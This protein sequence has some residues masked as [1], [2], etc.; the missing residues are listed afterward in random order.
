MEGGKITANDV[1]DEQLK[2]AINLIE[3]N[4]YYVVR[5]P[6]RELRN[7]ILN[8]LTR[9][10][11]DLHAIVEKVCGPK[12]DAKDQYRVRSCLRRMRDEGLVVMEDR[13][14]IDRIY[15]GTWRL[16]R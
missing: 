12:Y 7:T 9:E 6:N 11:Q 3:S 8:T 10:P 5:F 1:T 13:I 4:G 16:A 15:V 14:L 2:S